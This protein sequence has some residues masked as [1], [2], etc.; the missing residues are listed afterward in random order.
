MGVVLM[1]ACGLAVLAGAAGVLRW[2]AVEFRPPWRDDETRPRY[3]P[4]VVVRRYLWYVDLVLL[5]G[6]VSGVLVAGAGG[7]LV[8]RLLAVTAGDAAQGRL[9]EADQTVGAITVGGTLGFVIFVGIF[10][11]LATSAVFVMVRRYLPTGR[12]GGLAL[13]LVLLVVGATRLEPLRAGNPDF[14]LVGP[15]WLAVVAFAFVVLLHAMAVAAACGRIGRALPVLSR[16]PDRTW[17]WYIPLLLLLPGAGVGAVVVALG[18]VGV[19]LNRV[20][21]A[22]GWLSSA[23]A[24]K[25]GRLVIA[26][27][28]VVALPGFVGAVGD[29]VRSA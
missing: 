27:A 13:G 26:A 21:P 18:L 5:A 8:M 15:G 29:I 11:G 9:T 17:A 7:R 25:V 23:T 20:A 28:A 14:G 10:A 1:A 4:A 12:L 19:G 6:L 16:R 24:V 22:A 2:G 3:P